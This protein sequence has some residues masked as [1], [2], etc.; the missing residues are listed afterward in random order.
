MNTT[1]LRLVLGAVTALAVVACGGGG[2]SGSSSPT[3]ATKTRFVTG[4]IGGFGSVIVNGVHYDTK[5]ARVTLNGRSGSLSQLKVG[6][7]VHITAKVDA[8][9]NATATDIDEDRLLQGTVTAVDPVN[10]TLTV[11]GQVVQVDINTSFDS[12]IPGGTL[13]GIHVGDRVEVEG[14]VGADGVQLATRIE[15]AD[16]GDQEVEVTGAVTALDATSHRF[17]I[18]TQV[19]DYTSASLEGFPSGGPAEGDIVEVEGTTIQGDGSLLA[20]K[21]EK[22]GGEFDRDQHGDDGELEGLVTAVTDASHFDVNGHPVATTAA[23]TFVGGTAADLKLNAR[24]EVHGTVDS[25]GTLVAD[26]VAF[27]RPSSLKVSATVDSVSVPDPVNAPNVGTLVMLGVT[28]EVKADT[29]VEDDEAENQYF[30]LADVK[31]GDWLEVCGYPDP[32]DPTKVIV[33]KLER[34]GAQTEVEL[35]GTADNLDEANARFTVFGVQVATTPTTAFESG[36]TSTTAQ[37]FYAGAAGQEVEVEGSWAA[38]VL[39]ADKVRIEGQE[40]D[41]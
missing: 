36:E 3:G 9:G 26:R 29:R 16:A 22:K 17:T 27:E 30:K 2:G 15:L 10:G 39:T 12:S 21:V 8:Q 31:P 18:G 4:V 40:Q 6:Q 7:V 14:F 32:A 13:A 33:R 37:A 28:F 41:D 34:H 20:V 5:S 35:R 23:T 25:G 38:P 24:V 1:R 11:A 19:V